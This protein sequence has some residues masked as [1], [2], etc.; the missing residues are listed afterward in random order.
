[1][2]PGKLCPLDRPWG[3]AP[4][5]GGSVGTIAGPDLPRGFPP[6]PGRGNGAVLRTL[7]VVGALTGLGAQRPVGRLPG[8]G[9]RFSRETGGKRARGESFSPL[10]SLL[11]FLGPC[12]GSSLFSA[13]PAALYLTPVT[14]RP[15]AG[16]AGKGGFSDGKSTSHRPKPSPW[17]EGAPVRTLGRMRGRSTHPTEREKE[18]GGATG[19]SFYK[20]RLG[21][22]SPPHQSP[23][24]TAS[25]QGEAFAGGT[26]L[27]QN[28][29]LPTPCSRKMRIQIRARTWDSK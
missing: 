16:R 7:R 28:T 23:S 12:K 4:S 21:T 2:G 29:F 8:G 1:M 10:D 25:P 26:P 6:G 11:W 9:P 22:E 24:V 13:W 19:P 3:A 18:G 14:A 15:P 5:V 27:Q 20:E 17:G